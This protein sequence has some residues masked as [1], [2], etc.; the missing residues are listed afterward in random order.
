[1]TSVAPGGI[2]QAERLSHAIVLAGF[3][4]LTTILGG[5][6][7]EAPL[8][9]LGLQLTACAILCWCVLDGAK[10]ALST[11]A[12]WLLGLMAATIAAC[13]LQL[14]P[15][16]FSIWRDLPGR[17]EPA[18]VLEMLGGNDAMLPLSLA[19]QA[20]LEAL[21]W[22][23]P[24]IATL[25]LVLKLNMRTVVTAGRWTIPLVAAVAAVLGIAQVVTADTISLY[26]HEGPLKGHAAGFFQIVNYQPTLLLMA[27]PFL[28]VL[29]SR[30]GSRFDVGDSYLGRA[31]LLG[32]LMLVLVAG[33]A[34]AGSVAGYGLVVPVVLASLPIA[35]HRG[36]GL[37]VF[38]V[39]ILFI[40]VLAAAV[41]YVAGS[42]LLEGA[43]G[44]NFTDTGPLSRLGGWIT[45]V[46]MTREYFPVGAG[47]GAFRDAYAGFEDPALV[48]NSF[49]AHA[50]NDYLEVAVELG[51]P[52]IL[53][54]AGLVVWWLVTTI[55]LWRRP[56]EEGL[57]TRRAASVAF[58]VVLAHS[59][60]D[61]PV[62]TE[63]IA[64]LAAFCLGLMA[65]APKKSRP[66]ADM[67][68]TAHRHIQL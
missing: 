56:M 42:P 8:F 14:A 40:G 9:N 19:P 4:V 1:V 60:V 44:T 2:A 64:C 55:A 36:L 12:A 62:R 67:P 20:T 25:I 28:A 38:A 34:A 54:L 51:L 46:E 31:A 33:I 32:T 37:G 5:A 30:L 23:L 41:V 49:K 52:G 16:P 7:F 10:V 39:L 18:R 6:I 63:A 58:A 57:R 24:P 27:I 35:L 68:I 66:T 15:V 21:F 47:I 11:P 3:L 43:G 61:S 50:H 65:S 53:L 29:F 26:L 13:L 22:L 17:A 45:S 48:T 59:L